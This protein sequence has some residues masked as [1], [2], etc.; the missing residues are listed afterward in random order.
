MEHIINILLYTKYIVLL[1]AVVL[2]FIKNKKRQ[3]YQK[4]ISYI[5]LII[6]VLSLTQAL[7]G[8]HTGINLIIAIMCLVF[9]IAND[10]TH[11]TP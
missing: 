10:K 6:S 5:L 2:I 7:L 9:A 8:V 11:K 4:Q 3:L 1:Y